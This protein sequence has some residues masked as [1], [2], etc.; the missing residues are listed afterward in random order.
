MTFSASGTKSNLRF[1]ASLAVIG[2]LPSRWA[3]NP[4]SMSQGILFDETTQPFGR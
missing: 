1:A 3:L 4:S 2:A